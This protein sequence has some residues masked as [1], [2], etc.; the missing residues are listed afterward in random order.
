MVLIELIQVIGLEVGLCVYI[1]SKKSWNTLVRPSTEGG[2]VVRD[3][4]F[5]LLEYWILLY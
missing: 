4:E 3:V 2:V 5:V 1:I